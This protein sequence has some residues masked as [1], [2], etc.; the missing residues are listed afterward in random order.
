MIWSL[1]SLL[2]LEKVIILHCS[3]TNACLYGTDDMG[4]SLKL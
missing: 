1:H 2:A 4:I 3:L